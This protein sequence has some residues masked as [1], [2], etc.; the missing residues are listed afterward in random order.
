MRDD[1]YLNMDPILVD[2]IMSRMNHKTKEHRRYN[3]EHIRAFLEL[4]NVPADGHLIV[5]HSAPPP[6][7]WQYQPFPNHWIITET[8]E[9]AGY[10][11]I[12][13]DEITPV[14]VRVI[15]A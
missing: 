8:G 12:R 13:G 1:Y 7:T 3:Q 10:M 4:C 14:D 15:A 5:G 11:R 2:A 9:R 6:G